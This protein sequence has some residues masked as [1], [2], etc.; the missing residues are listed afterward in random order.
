MG[1][2]DMTFSPI[3][4]PVLGN[5]EFDLREVGNGEYFEIENGAM[6]GA[7]LVVFPFKGDLKGTFK[8]EGDQP[9]MNIGLKNGIYNAIGTNYYF[10][11]RAVGL[12]DK[13]NAVFVKGEWAV[14]EPEDYTVVVRNADGT[15]DLSKAVYAQLP[16]LVPGTLPLL[17]PFVE[18][19]TGE[20]NAFWVG[21]ATGVG[22]TTQPTIDA[23][24][25]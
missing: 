22:T 3:G 23:G 8:C 15:A 7:A 2:A 4:I 13:L 1:T 16:D 19:G 12:Y 24:G 18:G 11:G 20:W 5:V 6:V 21:P 14:T 25:P 9:Q 17:F 10:D